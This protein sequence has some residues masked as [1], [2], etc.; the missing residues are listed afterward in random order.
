LVIA[1][2]EEVKALPGRR[3]SAG[4]KQEEGSRR[5]E[6]AERILDAASELIQ[7]WGYN[8][9]TIDDI[10]KQAGVAKGTIYL[11]WKTRE[12]LFRALMNRE[13]MLMAEDIRQRMAS[14][15]EGMTLHGMMKNAMLVTMKRPLMK[16]VVL[17]DTDMMGEWARNEYSTEAYQKR[18]EG[19]KTFIEFL[20]SQGAVRTDSSFRDMMYLLSILS[21]GMLVVDQ[22]LPEE[23]QLSDEEAVEL[24]AKTVQRML[25]PPTAPPEDAA[26]EVSNVFKQYMDFVV[27]STK[28]Q[29]QKEMEL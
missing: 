10:A 15:P 12:D 9:T 26:R 13:E 1:R 14:D 18:L 19:Y 5:Q 22:W 23:L 7:R 17:R 24:L 3:N 28:E 11:H 27:N 4:L 29:S 6:R 25:E 16:A 21:I 8:K 20:R 2:R